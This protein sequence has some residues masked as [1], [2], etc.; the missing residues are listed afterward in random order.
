MYNNPAVPATAGSTL[1]FTGSNSVWLALGAFAL[2]AA[3][4]AII[5]IL[6]KPG[7]DSDHL[8]S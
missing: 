1:A 5:R 2:I 7:S 3:G 8:D 6:P 4:M